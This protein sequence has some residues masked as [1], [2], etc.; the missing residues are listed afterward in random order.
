MPSSSSYVSVAPEISDD[1]DPDSC[2]YVSSLLSAFLRNADRL[3]VIHAGGSLTYAELLDEVFRLARALESRGLGRGDGIAAFE[4]NTP[5]TLLINLASRLLGCYFVSLPT[6]AAPPEQAR[7]LESAEV[8]ALV[9]EPELSGDRAVELA[10]RRAVPA[11]LS[12]GPGPVGADLL[13]LAADEPGTPFPPRARDTDLGDILFT[14]GSTGSGPKAAVYT[15]ARLGE[16]T[17]AWLSFGG[18]GAASAAAYRDP[19]CRL[20]RF[21]ATTISPGVAIMPTLLNGGTIVL[22]RKFDAGAVLRAI[23]EQRITVLALYPSH[24]YQLLD[25]PDLTR[26]DL[27]TLRLLVY[28]G[29]PMSPT[30]LRQAITAF[31]P[32]L[33]QIYGQSETRILCHLGPE[34]HRLDRP[35]RL[36]SIG[37]P[38]PGVELQVRTDTGVAGVGE[39]G[40]IYVRTPYRMNYY[41]REPELTAKTIIDG[42]TRTTDLGYQDAEG[43]VYLVDRVR[44]IVLVN[45][46]NCYTVDIENVL[47]GHPAVREAVAVG[48][49]DP[50]TGEA[51]HAAV[52]RHPH[53]QVSGSE[54]PEVGS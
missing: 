38:L 19:D 43:Y 13:A 10:D 40:E 46:N 47:T 51:L 4:D 21:F 24:L 6:Y 28:Y 18:R 5:G 35:E 31:G 1:L 32:V 39:I 20:L 37:R 49:P 8:L 22:Q 53:V 17:K 27:S 34:D 7:M 52:G 25:H 23:E 30:R 33:C 12:L 2:F 16:L 14:S 26:V 41:W 44:D 15:F 48:M 11:I 54:L 45:A 50:H 42:W 29:A 3:A 36:R 9:Y